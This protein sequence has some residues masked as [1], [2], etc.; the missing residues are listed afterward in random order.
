MEVALPPLGPQIPQ[1]LSVKLSYGE[2]S[3]GKGEP[4]D[5]DAVR[6]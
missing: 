4:L 1:P 5:H 3:R 2:G 6:I